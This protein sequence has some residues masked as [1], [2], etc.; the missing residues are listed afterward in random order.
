MAVLEDAKPSNIQL[1]NEA[2]ERFGADKTAI[3]FERE[4]SDEELCQAAKD[5]FDEGAFFHY[6]KKG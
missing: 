3:L 1:V 5:Y 2:S 4:C 6:N